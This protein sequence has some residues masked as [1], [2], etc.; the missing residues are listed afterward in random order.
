MG[1]GQFFRMPVTFAPVPSYLLRGSSYLWVFFS[2]S[3]LPQNQPFQSA[4]LNIMQ[5]VYLLKV[6]ITRKKKD[7]E[8]LH[9]KGGP[10]KVQ[11]KWCDSLAQVLRNCNRRE[12]N[13][14]LML[15]LFR[16]KAWILTIRLRKLRISP[17]TIIYISM[18]FESITVMVHLWE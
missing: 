17:D 13:T 2:G 15:N 16:W 18:T 7:D 12:S 4:E 9:S 1:F 11:K 5:Q 3:L 6:Y 14:D 8:Y 10:K